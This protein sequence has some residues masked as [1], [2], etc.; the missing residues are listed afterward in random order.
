MNS[1][2]SSDNF[3]I[4]TQAM[5]DFIQIIEL[6]FQTYGNLPLYNVIINQAFTES[7]QNSQQTHSMLRTMSATTAGFYMNY[8]VSFIEYTAIVPSTLQT[9]V[10]SSIDTSISSGWFTNELQTSQ[11]NVLTQMSSS[12]AA[13]VSNPS[14]LSVDNS[15]QSQSTNK[16]SAISKTNEIVIIVVILLSVFAFIIGYYMYYYIYNKPIE[17]IISDGIIQNTVKSPIEMIDRKRTTIIGTGVT[18]D[19]SN[20]AMTTI[21]ASNFDNMDVFASNNEDFSYD[22]P[23]ITL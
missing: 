7:G 14:V 19:T 20:N 2:Q 11:S 9:Q 5:N 18:V 6:L 15:D 22:S 3:N 1:L 17:V 4:N 13:S 8:T 16:S 12:I 23:N 10:S 21:R